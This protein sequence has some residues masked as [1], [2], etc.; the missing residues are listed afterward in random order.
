MWLGRMLVGHG[1]AGMVLLGAA[2]V[3]HV[4][5][6]AVWFCSVRYGMLWHVVA[7]VVRQ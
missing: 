4:S 3:R 6:G 1:V 7:G 5:A 2:A